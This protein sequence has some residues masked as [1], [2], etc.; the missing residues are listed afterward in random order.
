MLDFLINITKV[1]STIL[2][3][4][5]SLCVFSYCPWQRIDFFQSFAQEELALRILYFPVQMQHGKV[6]CKTNSDQ[7]NR[8]KTSTLCFIAPTVLIWQ[9]QSNILVNIVKL[10]QRLKRI[11]D[12][13]Y[14]AWFWVSIKT[15]LWSKMRPLF[16]YCS[17]RHNSF[18]QFLARGNFSWENPRYYPFP[19]YWVTP[20]VYGCLSV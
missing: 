12:N 11:S 16:A 19:R 14:S 8:D 9:L 10:I 13:C 4:L 15:E 18:I 5:L 2:D 6:L 7:K 20:S 3:Q 17:S 1:C